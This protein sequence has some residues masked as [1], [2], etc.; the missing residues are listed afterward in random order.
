VIE[1]ASIRTP[2]V[3]KT[4]GDVEGLIQRLPPEGAQ[5]YGGMLRN[6][7]KRAYAREMNGSSPEVV[8]RA[9]LHALTARRPKIRYVVGKGSRPLTILP[10][11]LPERLMDRLETELFGLH[12]SA[13]GR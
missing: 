10:R 2:A 8:A 5:R 3:D 1:P 6:F 11:L 12:V 9:V 4:L 13:Q 7:N